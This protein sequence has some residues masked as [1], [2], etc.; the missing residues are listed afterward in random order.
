MASLD[1][2]GLMRKLQGIAT[3]YSVRRKCGRPGGDVA[4]ASGA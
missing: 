1:V 3:T 2:G 4:T